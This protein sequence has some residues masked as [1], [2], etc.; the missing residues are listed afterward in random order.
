MRQKSGPER[1]PAEQVVKDIRRAAGGTR[2]L[3]FFWHS[4]F[5]VESAGHRLA[6]VDICQR[7][8]A[9]LARETFDGEIR[10]LLQRFRDRGQG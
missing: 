1:A 6:T 3:P 7:P 5:S 8:P 2:L 4:D 10:V 9:G